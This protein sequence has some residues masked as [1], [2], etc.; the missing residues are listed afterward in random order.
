M[1]RLLAIRSEV[2]K[3]VHWMPEVL[4]AAEIAFRG[5]HGGMPEQ[6]LNL[7]QFTAAIV[8]QL[9]AGAAQVVWGDVFHPGL[10]TSLVHHVPHYVF[11][12][13]AAPNLTHP[14]DGAKQASFS[15]SSG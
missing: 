7:L 9:G 8:A 3:V 10:G 14:A 6:E 15:D 13:A 1:F 11:A 5:L 2:K 12:D 4:F